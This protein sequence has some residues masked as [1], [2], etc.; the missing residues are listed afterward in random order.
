MSTLRILLVGAGI[1]GLTAAIALRRAGHD[2]TLVEKSPEASP[3]GAGIVLAPN[4]AQL[5][6]SLGVDVAGRGH[7]LAAVDVVRADGSLLSRIDAAALG[8]SSAW[9]AFGPTWSFARP[10]LHA[11]LVAALPAGVDFRYGCGVV[12]LLEEE[13]GVTAGFEVGTAGERYDVVVAADGLRSVCREMVMGTSRYRYSGVTCYR[14]LVRLDGFRHA[15]E[16]WGGQ[17]RVGLVPL[18][19][20][21][22]YYYLVHTS[23]PRSAALSFPD[24]F[25]RVFGGFRGD[26]ARLLDAIPEAPPLHHDLDELDAPLWGCSR[27][28]L[29]GDAAH[30]MTP[31]QGQGAAMAIEDAVA[32]AGALSRGVGG[33]IDRYVAVRHDRVRRMQLD[34]RRVGKLAHLNNPAVCLLR[35]GLMRAIP[36]SWTEAQY[37]RVVEPGLALLPR[38]G[39]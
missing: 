1:G 24:G 38:V 3:I 5:L 22:V 35:D 30:G 8:A 37:R 2:V 27:V 32:V 25:R 16:A 29:L 20:G 7:Q 12:S 39:G 21:R 26:V 36:V 14:G 11:A 23:P 13:G 4:A 31:N 15:V 10:E 17:A 28:L 33:A 18:S 9:G 34:S 6:A 19:G